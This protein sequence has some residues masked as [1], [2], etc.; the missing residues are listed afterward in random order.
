FLIVL[1]RLVF[2]QGRRRQIIAP[3][4]ASAGKMVLNSG[5]DGTGSECRR[6]D[7]RRIAE[8]AVICGSNASPAAPCKVRAIKVV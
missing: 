4:L 3:A 7:C 5:D 2:A 8:G 6:H 1:E